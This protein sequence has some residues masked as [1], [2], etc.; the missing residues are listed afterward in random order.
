MKHR[1][2]WRKLA[3]AADYRLV[4]ID[5]HS[6]ILPGLDDG[7]RTLEEAREIGRA[8]AEEGVTAI[9]ATPHV[10]DDYPTR[11]GA[12]EAAVDAL[13]RDFDAQGIPIQVLR[14]GEVSIDAVWELSASDLR[15]FALGGSERY[16]LLEFPYTGWP[17]A[18][19]LA[20]TTVLGHGLTPVLAHPERN[21]QVQDRPDRL[22]TVVER[23]AVVQVT[24]ASVDG[25]LGAAPRV[26]AERLLEL[27]I[28]HVVATDV[29][30]PH[31][32]REGMHAAAQVIGDPVADHVTR[33]VPAA[34]VAGEPL[35]ALSAPVASG[36]EPDARSGSTHLLF[37][38]SPRGYMI[39][40]REGLAPERG[41]A[42]TVPGRDR[43]TF[44]VTKIGSSPYPGDM[45]LCVYLVVL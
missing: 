22:L 40:E 16:L 27:E 43:E 30:G 4:V 41:A 5:L 11:P 10:R 7:A 34:I 33:A 21:P 18:L 45:R 12:M 23:G 25:R 36:A 17:P 19:D 14:G 37:V 15:R 28:V 13:R 42:L 9:A 1:D 44:A 26:A 39:V 31:I 6:H 32:R 38:P 2:A 29:H 3:A 35:P 24:A 20:I 8:A